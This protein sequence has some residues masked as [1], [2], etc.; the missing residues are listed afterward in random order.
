MN[1]NPDGI[2]ADANKR[3]FT[4]IWIPAEIWE[5]ANIPGLA[6]MLYAEIS[7]FG[8]AG[9]WKKSDELREPLGV[10]AETFQK[11]CRQ[12]RE[13]GYITERRAFG[14]IIRQS[15]LGFYHQQEIPADEHQENPGDEHT[16]KPGV[17]LE[18]SKNKE[19][20][21]TGDE[22]VADESKSYGRE[23]INEIVALWESETGTS[24]K[25]QQNQRRQIYNLLRRHGYEATIALVKLVGES[26]RVHDQFAPQIATPADLTGK[27]SKLERLRL[28]DERRK[29]GRPFGQQG[30][31]QPARI[32]RPFDPNEWDRHYEISDEERA[33]VSQRFKEA[34]KTLPFL[35]KGGQK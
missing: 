16:E 12:L 35:N 30:N 9:C 13:A 1:N 11:L 29:L 3:K 20:I 34:R 28:W 21:H 24:L 23:D 2:P 18:Y 22:T 14:R 5:D 6:K 33:E 19:R 10:S 4:G 25:G 7:S 31:P 15:T 27:Y 8:G 26:R 32:P 17:Q